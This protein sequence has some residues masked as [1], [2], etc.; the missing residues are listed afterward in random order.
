MM[1]LTKSVENLEKMKTIII[2]NLEKSEKKME[3][4]LVC[5]AEQNQKDL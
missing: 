1:K 5:F 4:T 3:E 2:F